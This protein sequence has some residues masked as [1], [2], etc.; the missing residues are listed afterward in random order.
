MRNSVL[1][2]TNGDYFNKYFTEKFYANALPF[3]EAMMDGE[4]DLQIY[5]A[6]FIKL[7]AAELGVSEGFYTSKACVCDA[8]NKEAYDKLCLWF[9]KDTFCQTNLLTLLA[10]LEQI[11]Y[12]GEV[13]LNYIDDESFAVIERDIFVSLGVYANAYKSVFI[14]KQAPE[15]LG[16][17]IPNAFELYLDYHSPEGALS[18]LVKENINEDEDTLIRILLENSKEYGLS[19][20]QA[21]RLINAHKKTS[22]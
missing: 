5:S 9:G 16:V 6:S 17:L 15:T 2:I 19:D 21:K 22:F 1:H 20:L 4:T 3:R 12:R 11:S 18:R 10:Y 7:R 13:V 8:L 14:Q